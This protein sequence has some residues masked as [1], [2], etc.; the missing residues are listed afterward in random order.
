MLLSGQPLRHTE[1]AFGLQTMP[2]FCS[3]GSQLPEDA[4]FCHKCGKP[5]RD[6]I[7][8]ENPVPAFA[9]PV[10]PPPPRPEPLLLNFHN[11]IAVRTALLMAACATILGLTVLP[12]LNWV[13]AGF[14][15]V[16]FYRRRT[17]S[18]L[19][20][21]AGMRLG[22]ITGIL[23][24]GMWIVIFTAQELPDAFSGHLSGLFLQRMQS[25]PGQD[26][27]VQQQ[28]AKFIQSGPGVFTVLLFSLVVMFIIITCLSVAGGALGA[29][30]TGRN[31]PAAGR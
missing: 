30:L 8:V 5:Q 12:F 3:C 16:L 11:R 28:M 21:S 1:D 31:Q 23:M 15:A 13:A 14:F 10:A 17:G 2:E 24:S 20:V 4:L 27:A 19:N 7:E 6:V 25:L 26:P 18:L 9:V 22:W 29:K